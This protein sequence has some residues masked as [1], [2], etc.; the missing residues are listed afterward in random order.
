MKFRI[1][2]K[3]LIHLFYVTGICNK[4]NNETKYYDA[5]AIYFLFTK[6]ECLI[7]KYKVKKVK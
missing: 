4:C 7:C 6:R 1:D 2:W 3:D 5:D